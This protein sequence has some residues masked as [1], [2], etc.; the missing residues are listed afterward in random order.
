MW[1]T[2]LRWSHPS[3]N[4]SNMHTSSFRR[5]CATEPK[6]SHRPDFGRHNPRCDPLLGRKVES[7]H[8]H[9]SQPEGP[10]AQV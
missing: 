4:P 6:P 3:S 8:A 10:V 9:A 7:V 1:S 2:T 5:T